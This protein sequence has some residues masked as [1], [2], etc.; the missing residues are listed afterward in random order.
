MWPWKR[1]KADNPLHDRLATI[2]RK[3]TDLELEWIN[4]YDKAR[5]MMG[6][7]AKRAEVV[8][9]KLRQ[10]APPGPD[11][12]GAQPDPYAHMDPVTRAILERRGQIPK[13]RR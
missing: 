4:F 9:G 12:D 3:F 1:H 2:E 13:V 6:R 11:G 7:I 5:T 8:E 10:D